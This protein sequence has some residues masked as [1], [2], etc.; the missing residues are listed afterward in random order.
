MGWAR[1][2]EAGERVSA[3][4]KDGVI[5][6]GKIVDVLDVM[7]FIKFDDGTETFCYKADRNLKRR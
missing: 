5:K 4:Y 7:M 2:V 3:P 6:D 1:R